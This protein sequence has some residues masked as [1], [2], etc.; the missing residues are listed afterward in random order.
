MSDLFFTANTTEF[1]KDA[2]DKAE[3]ALGT[4]RSELPRASGPRAV[5]LQ[6][7]ISA[8]IAQLG[9]IAEELRRRGVNDA[10]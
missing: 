6:G 9:S 4:Y 8:T 1:L 7:R 2:R 10:R 5:Y 3:K